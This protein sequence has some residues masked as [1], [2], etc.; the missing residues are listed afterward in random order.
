MLKCH[1]DNLVNISSAT[2]LYTKKIVKVATFVLQFSTI[3]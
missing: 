2:E 3:F 1:Q